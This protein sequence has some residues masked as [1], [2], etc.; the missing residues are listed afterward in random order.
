MLKDKLLQDLQEHFE[1]LGQVRNLAQNYDE[2]LFNYLLEESKYKEEFQNRFFI[3][4][5]KALIFKINEFLTFLDLKNLSGS[6]TSYANKIGLAN[7]TKSLL[8][9]NNEVVLNFAFKDGVIKGGQ[10][11]DEQKSKEIFFNEILARDEIDVLFDKK[12]LQNFELIGE[13]KNPQEYL[14]DNPNLLIKGN[15]LLAL[16]SLKK[17]YANKVKLIYIDPPYNTGNDSFNYNDKFNHSTWLTFMKNRLEVAREFLRDDGVIFVQCDD[18]EQ[19]YL[20]VLMDEIF[21]R[22]NFVSCI[23]CKVK[24]AGGLTTDTEMFFNCVEYILCYGKGIKLLNYNS[25]KIETEVIN[26]FSKTASQYNSRIYNIDLSKKE[27]IVE[28]DKI[29][30]YRIPKGSFTIERLPIKSMSEKD[31]FEIRNEVFRLTALS[32]GIGK[33]LKRHIED[34]TNSEDLFIFEYIPSKG[35]DKNKLSQYLLYKNQTITM[36]NKL[37]KVD[38]KNEKIIKLEP[39]SNIFTDDFWQGISNEGQ[40]TLKNGK[41][42]EALLQRIIEISTNENDI[43]MDFFAGSGTTLAVAH[44]MKRKWIGIEQMDYIKDI[45]KERLKKVV[46]GEQGGISKAVNWQGGG[47]FVYAELMPLNAVYKE[48]IQN[49]NDE[50]ELDGI[51]QELKTKAFLDYRVDI[52]EILK[53]K[54]FEN[55]DLE[56]KKEILKLVLDSNM[57]Y[58]LYGDIKDEDYAISKETIKLNKIFYGDENV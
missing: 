31:F 4:N 34:F 52:N 32:G 2:R 25:I 46:E 43:V 6:F 49:L 35:K 5:K 56:S 42:P 18:N 57:D 26:S 37:I 9:T 29:K 58:V 47:S 24:S 33:K 30:Y 21:G 7:K 14:K 27:F 54:E 17:L 53:D 50:K 10:S 15:N 19:A 44:K 48:K 1:T 12:A 20:K 13:S 51:Y 8:K 28:K 22:D 39:I 23:T 41:K 38:N 11:K 45:T 40:I 16:H 3:F 55:L 36:L